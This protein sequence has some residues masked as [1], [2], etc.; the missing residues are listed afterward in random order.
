MSVQSN[1]HDT[2]LI[3][4][5]GGM[6]ASYTSAVVTTLLRGGIF[7]DWTAGI[8]AGATHTVNYVSRDARRSRLVFTDF[9]SD[10]NF[11]SLRT[12]LAGKGLFN[13]EYIYHQTSAPG[14]AL[15]FDMETYAANPARVRIGG[16]NAV[17][18]E[19]AYW[20]RDDLTT[21]LDLRTRVQASS[22]MPGLMPVVTIG[23]EQWVDGAIGS[24]GGIALDA[25]EADGFSRFMAV[26]T[27]PRDYWK[28]PPRNPRL[29][30]RALRKYPAVADAVLTRSIRY[31][32]TKQRLLELEREGR[33]ILFFPE[34]FTV[35]STEKNLSKL[36]ASYIDG[37]EQSKRDLPM[38]KEFVGL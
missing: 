35:S 20:G 5:G 10:P 15:P 11:G 29:I 9:V 3:F 13:A 4:E 32:A 18:G 37:L 1:V 22:T 8:S 17:T 6:R 36:R 33:A 38:W 21:S 14:E 30:E 12:F 26:L 28:T 34:G 31:N 24:S 25:A 23:D 16:F 19:T 27:R 7:F 2:A